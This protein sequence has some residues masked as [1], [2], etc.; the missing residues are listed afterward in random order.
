MCQLKE[1]LQKWNIQL[2]GFPNID[3]KDSALE[4]LEFYQKHLKFLMNTKKYLQNK[5]TETLNA[6][7][8]KLYA[9]PKGINDLTGPQEVA[10]LSQLLEEVEF[11]GS[12]YNFRY[13]FT[14]GLLYFL[15]DNYLAAGKH[16]KQAQQLYTTYD[17]GNSDHFA[18]YGAPC[19]ARESLVE[20]LFSSK[21]QYNW[22]PR[23]MICGAVPK[24]LINHFTIKKINRPYFYC[25]TDADASKQEA[26]GPKFE[27][28][29]DQISKE[30]LALNN[31]GGLPLINSPKWCRRL[32]AVN[33]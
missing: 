21:T 17:L 3:V 26:V 5:V 18:H 6:P 20:A 31:L 16:L 13:Q 27:D 9:N 1:H 23:D 14:R 32:K 7:K 10:L 15:Q 28:V 33:R 29:L 2:T 24:E 30:N 19:S 4:Q 11:S 8:Y 25:S 12:Q 22:A